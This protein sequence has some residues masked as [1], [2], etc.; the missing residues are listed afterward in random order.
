MTNNLF[1][2]ALQIVDSSINNK[3]DFNAIHFK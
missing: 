3:G 1:T 2:N